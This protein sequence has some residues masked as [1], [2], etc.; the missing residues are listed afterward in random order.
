MGNQRKPSSAKLGVYHGFNEWSVSMRRTCKVWTS[1]G[2]TTAGGAMVAESRNQLRRPLRR[3]IIRRMVSAMAT[4]AGSCQNCHIQDAPGPLF[5]RRLRAVMSSRIA[6]R[7]V[8]WASD[9]VAEVLWFRSISFR[10]W[11]VMASRR[12]FNAR[13]RW[14]RFWLRIPPRRTTAVRTMNADA[15]RA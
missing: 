6:L 13:Y 15:G 5:Q 2:S 7:A 3:P 4:K 12:G 9:G 11:L 1:P 8:F 10:V 14:R